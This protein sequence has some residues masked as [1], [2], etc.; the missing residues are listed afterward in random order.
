MRQVLC[1]SDQVRLSKLK[2]TSDFEL[3]LQLKV[4]TTGDA[5]KLTEL[6]AT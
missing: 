1:L 2:R 4:G 3:C 5:K 6:A